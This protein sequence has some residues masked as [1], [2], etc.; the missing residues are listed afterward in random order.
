LQAGG[1]LEAGRVHCPSCGAAL[2]VPP[3]GVSVAP[4]APVRFR[5]DQQRSE[6]EMDMTPMVDVTFLL[7]I[8]FMVTATF[9]MQKAFEVPAPEESEPSTQVK[10]LQDFEDDPQFVVVRVDEFNTFY[11]LAA[12]WDEER[13]SPS[14]QELL[15]NLREARRGDG[16]GVVP[17]RLLVVANGEA[18]HEKVVTALDA[19]TAV[20]M[21][22]VQLVTVEE[23][24]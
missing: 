18:F 15:I 21:E 9:A 8:F 23:E 19:G 17:T 6:A 1:E 2:I 4:E 12:H 5:D 7:L 13:E 14:K 11:V 24:I 22:E 3:P 20:G 10:S 16:S